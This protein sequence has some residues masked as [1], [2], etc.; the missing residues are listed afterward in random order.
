MHRRALT[1]PLVYWALPARGC[2]RNDN[3]LVCC[4]QR[5]TRHQSRRKNGHLALSLNTCL[6]ALATRSIRLPSGSRANDFSH[7][8][9]SDVGPASP[10]PAVGRI[11]DVER[12]FEQ[13]VAGLDEDLRRA[14]LARSHTA[15]RSVT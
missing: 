11:C 4:K 8:P 9:V 1:T 6:V 10:T 14:Q 3:V 13:G 12:S 15:R 5:A 2:T 7:N